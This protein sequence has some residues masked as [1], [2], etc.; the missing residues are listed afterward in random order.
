MWS[1]AESARGLKAEWAGHEFLLEDFKSA[2]I[3]RKCL[4]DDVIDD[5]S[6]AAISCCL[7]VLI[8][9]GVI[10]GSAIIRHSVT[11]VAD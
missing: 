9:H 5:G 10:Y 1:G 11:A 4:I 2:R 3:V 7:V 6:S 8:S